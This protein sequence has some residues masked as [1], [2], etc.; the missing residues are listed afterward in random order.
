MEHH[1]LKIVIDFGGCQRIG[2][3]FY[4]VT[5]ANLLIKL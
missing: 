5:E 2:L 3:A 4:N 1:I